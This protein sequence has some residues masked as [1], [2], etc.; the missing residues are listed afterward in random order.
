VPAPG[1]LGVSTHVRRQRHL[2]VG[3]AIV[4]RFAGFGCRVREVTEPAR[5]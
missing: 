1:S 4:Q 3:I 5:L 2:I